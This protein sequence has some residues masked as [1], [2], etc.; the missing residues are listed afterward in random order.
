MKILIVGAEEIYSIENY[1]VKYLRQAGVDVYVFPAQGIFYQHYKTLI[2]KILFRLGM[3]SIYKSIN[4]RFKQMIGEVQPEIIWIFKGMEIFPS[5]L[6]WI[7]SRKIK[8]VNYNPDNPF[9]FSGRGS[10][11]KN[12]T[13][14]ILLYDLHFTYNLEVKSKLENDFKIQTAWLPFGFDISGDLLRQCEEQAEV[15]EVCFVGNPDKAR[16]EFIISL[17]KKGITIS[18]YGHHWNEFVEHP[19]VKLYPPVYGDELWKTLRRYR[20]QL[21]LMRIHNLNSHNMRTFEIPGV[22]GIMIAPDTTE[23]RILF[24]D[25]KEAFFFRNVNECVDLIKNILS[26]SIQE[27]AKIRKESRKRSITSGYD[28]QNRVNY[29]LNEL[30]NLIG[31]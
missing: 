12:I 13:D 27:A 24:E 23:H 29:S 17:A 14:S 26:L 10:G 31:N 9:I 6:Q 3:P 21:N 16:V 30:N 5:T 4:R 8:L 25:R 18:I 7:K 28:Y 1:Y 2:S 19:L 22:G 20:L 11:N 15:N